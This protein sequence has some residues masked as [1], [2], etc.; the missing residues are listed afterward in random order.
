MK[1]CAFAD[2]AEYDFEDILRELW[3]ENVLME[4]LDIV[5]QLR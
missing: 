1:S 2:D 4:V 5:A 3:I